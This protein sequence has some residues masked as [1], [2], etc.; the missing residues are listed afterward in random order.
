[1]LENLAQL[2]NAVKDPEKLLQDMDINRLR[3][4]IYRDV[5]SVAMETLKGTVSVAKFNFLF[6]VVSK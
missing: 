4:V 2:N 5:V 3:A 6:N 1:M